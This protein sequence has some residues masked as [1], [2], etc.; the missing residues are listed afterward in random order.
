ME[1]VATIIVILVCVGV[2]K[3]KKHHGG[4]HGKGKCIRDC[5]QCPNHCRHQ[6]RFPP[7]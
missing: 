4:H 5:S 1:I 2:I 6:G 7:K 3:H